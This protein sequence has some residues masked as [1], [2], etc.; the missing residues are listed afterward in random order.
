MNCSK[1][2]ASESFVR[3]RSCFWRSSVSRLRVDSICCW[4]HWRASGSSMNVNSTPIERQYV[5]SSRRMISRSVRTGGTPARSVVGKGSSRSS[6]RSPK[7][8]RSSSGGV[9]GGRPSGSTCAK[10]W[11]RTR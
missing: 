9:A 8:V 4:S 11:P 1:I 2:S 5:S 3:I 10:R 6:T 7:F